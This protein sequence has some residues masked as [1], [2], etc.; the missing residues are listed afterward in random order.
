MNDSLSSAVLANRRQF[1]GT[2]ASSFTLFFGLGP[3]GLST[4]AQA[5]AVASAT[6]NTW[7]TIASD[8]SVTLT[9]GSSDMG[10]G[11]FSGLAQ[12]LS[13]DLMVDYGRVRLVQGAPT[14]A[15]RRPS[16]PPS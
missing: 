16:A 3:V 13:E 11:S 12:V 1:L 5:Q 6:V 9:I 10:Q 14:L 15:T 7:L 8:N 4:T 2:A